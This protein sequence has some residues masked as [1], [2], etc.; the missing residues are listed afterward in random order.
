MDIRIGEGREKDP[1]SHAAEAQGSE[2]NEE[3]T[4]REQVK[5]CSGSCQ[6]KQDGWQEKDERRDEAKD[7]TKK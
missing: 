6:K 4:R 3:S 5:I 2:N 1:R 7:Q